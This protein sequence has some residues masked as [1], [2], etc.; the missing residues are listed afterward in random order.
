MP[1]KL[2]QPETGRPPLADNIGAAKAVRASFSILESANA[3]PH[4]ISDDRSMSAT[5]TPLAYCVPE[6]RAFL[7]LV[8][9]SV[10]QQKGQQNIS[11][12][13]LTNYR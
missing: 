12:C 6:P 8:L 5:A 4:R 9:L 11:L 1:S 10:N 13:T 2:Y 7:T 3:L